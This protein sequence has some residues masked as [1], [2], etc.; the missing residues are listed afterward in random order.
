[1]EE[2]TINSL[3][4]MQQNVINAPTGSVSNSGTVVGTIA[5]FLQ[6]IVPVRLPSLVFRNWASN[7]Y[8]EKALDLLEPTKLNYGDALSRGHLIVQSSNV[9]IKSTGDPVLGLYCRRCDDAKGREQS[10][11]GPTSEQGCGSV[12]RGRPVQVAAGFY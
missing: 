2:A 7:I 11:A 10:A 5:P 4:M 6:H 9:A 12:H 8:L 1:M 3:V